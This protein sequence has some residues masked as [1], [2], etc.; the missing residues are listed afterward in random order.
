MTPLPE[1]PIVVFVMAS[2]KDE[3]ATIADV[4]LKEKAVACVNIMPG[5]ESRY[6]WEGKLQSAAEVL[7]IAKTTRE[8]FPKVEALAKAHHSYQVPEI[9]ALP[10]VDGHAPYLAWLKDNS[11]S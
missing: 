8:A 6:W 10:I 5:V 7:L 3:A 11:K 9:I 2:S 1:E 4:L